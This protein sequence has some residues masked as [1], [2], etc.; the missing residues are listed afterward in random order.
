MAVDDRGLV[1]IGPDLP[2]PTRFAKP[3][4]ICIGVDKIISVWP[5]I[6]IAGAKE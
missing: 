4:P 3:S 1:P 5:P 6:V 2:R